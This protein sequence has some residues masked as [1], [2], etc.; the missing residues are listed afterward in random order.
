VVLSRFGVFLGDGSSKTQ[1]KLFVTQ[2]RSKDKSQ[3]A[4]GNWKPRC[5]P[6]GGSPPPGRAQVQALSVE[7][8]SPAAF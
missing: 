2:K 7:V 1:Q 6:G 5:R 8:V 3:L 4:I